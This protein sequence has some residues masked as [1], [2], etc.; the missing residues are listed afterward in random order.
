MAE[1]KNDFYVDDSRILSLML[2]LYKAKEVVNN[3]ELIKTDLKIK[4][5]R[6]L[7]WAEEQIE[8]P[9]SIE[10]TKNLANEKKSHLKE[11]T[12]ITKR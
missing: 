8:K 12:H 11:E 10:M 3:S 5:N 4:N 6:I 9:I 7:D 2:D 1:L